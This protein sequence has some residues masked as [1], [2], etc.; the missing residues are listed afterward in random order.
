MKKYKEN[1]TK[2]ESRGMTGLNKNMQLL[3]EESLSIAAGGKNEKGFM[4]TEPLKMNGVSFLLTSSVSQELNAG[5]WKCGKCG[6][7]VPYPH[8]DLHSKG[9]ETTTPTDDGGRIIQ[10]CGVSLRRVPP[11]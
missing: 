6:Q 5:M 1:S 9:L 3:D 2:S 11:V 10:K 7:N 4:G 8:L